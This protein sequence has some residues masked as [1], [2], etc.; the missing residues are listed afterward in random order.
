MG[1]EGVLMVVGHSATPMPTGYQCYA[2]V[3]RVDA[4]AIASV[5]ISGSAVTNKSWETV[6]L[7]RGD[8]I[9]LE[10]P[11]TSITL[12]ADADSVFC[13]LEHI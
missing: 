5:T 9:P 11:I 2:I 6:A 8:Y 12:T 13:Y 4:T 3:V 10:V 7:L 1:S